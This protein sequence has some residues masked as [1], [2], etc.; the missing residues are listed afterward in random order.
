PS[1]CDGRGEAG[2]STNASSRF[3][4]RAGDASAFASGPE[5]DA[6]VLAMAAALGQQMQL[7]RSNAT[8]LLA[9]R[10]T[11]T[12]A[13]ARNHGSSGEP[14]C[15]QLMSLDSDLAGFFAV[16]DRQGIDYAVVL[17]A[18]D[19]SGRVP[20]LFWWKGIAP[21]ERGETATTADIVPTLIRL[22]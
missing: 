12:G 7:G 22:I 14:A 18:T 17:T 13:V 10:L 4:R 8:D 16:L 20:I 9:V 15:L 21:I 1:F 2:A 3:A 5:L 6:S 19:Q 11:A